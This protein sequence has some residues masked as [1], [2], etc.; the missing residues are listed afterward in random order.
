MGL[1]LAIWIQNDFK[2][3]QPQSQGLSIF[4]WPV[5]AM[6][7][8]AFARV[9]HE[10]EF[11][12]AQRF[13]FVADLNRYIVARG[14]LRYL[15]AR[16]LNCHPHH[17][18]FDYKDHG[19]PV[20]PQHDVQFNISHAGDWVL[21]VIAHG[22]AV[23]I[24]VEAWREVACLSLAKRFF[25]E[26]EYQALLTLS[27]SAL[28]AAF[29]HI[30]VQKEAFV[31]ALGDGLQYGLEKFSVIAP[32]GAG[33]SDPSLASQWQVKTLDMPMGYSAAYAVPAVQT[34]PVYQYQM[35]MDG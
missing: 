8:E 23:G 18:I 7:P 24:D 19:K 20:L 21:A 35:A 16:Y 9:L 28:P 12:R 32:P 2:N 15:L 10:T 13:R 6:N 3:F 4:R 1:S 34:A 17:V 27:D 31:K 5:V 11:A 29:F 25:S 30:W 33:L 22:H 26:S 14:G